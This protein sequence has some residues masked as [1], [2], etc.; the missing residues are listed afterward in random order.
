MAIT[1]LTGAVE[2]SPQLKE[3]FP[4]EPDPV[5][6]A[7][8]L[9]AEA[10]HLRRREDRKYPEFRADVKKTLRRIKT[11][12]E[13]PERPRRAAHRPVEN[14]ERDRRVYLMSRIHPD[15]PHTYVAEW[16]ERLFV[17]ERMKGGR[18]LGT[19]EEVKRFF[20]EFQEFEG[21]NDKEK[22]LIARKQRGAKRKKATELRTKVTP[23]MVRSIVKRQQKKEE[24][25]VRLFL[26]QMPSLQ[27]FV[28]QQ[29]DQPE[30]LSP[31]HLI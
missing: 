31:L 18:W 8:S 9:T 7:M 17:E 6:E 25:I 27:N 14:A 12:I 2:R 20:G 4:R 5:E 10:L 22:A 29:P 3:L 24:S 28:S 19:L 23:K 11:F 26:E 30:S 1:E 21:K 16:Y 13:R 15:I